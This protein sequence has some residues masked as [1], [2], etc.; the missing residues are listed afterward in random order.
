MYIACGGEANAE[1]GTTNLHV[2]VAD[3][4]NFVTWTYNSRHAAAIWH[5]FPRNTTTAI[6]IYLR[7]TRLDLGKQDPIQSQSVYLTNS[8]LEQLALRHKVAPWII[9]QRMG[10]MLFIP[11]GCPHQVCNTVRRV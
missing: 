8:D 2:D 5:I 4:V 9:H 3:A 7:H 11:A 6:R 1:K 10:D